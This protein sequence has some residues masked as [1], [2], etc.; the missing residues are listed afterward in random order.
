M[1]PKK[2]IIYQY[3]SD[4]S[5]MNLA[6]EFEGDLPKA[7]YEDMIK[8]D[9]MRKRRAA[10]AKYTGKNQDRDMFDDGMEI[11]VGTH[12]EDNI[13]QHK[14]LKR[15]G[16]ATRGTAKVVR[17]RGVVFDY[18]NDIIDLRVRPTHKTIGGKPIM[19]TPKTMKLSVDFGDQFNHVNK[20]GSYKMNINVHPEK[21]RLDDSK[22]KKIGVMGI[23][24]QV[25]GEKNGL[26]VL[27][28]GITNMGKMKRKMPSV[29]MFKGT[30]L[31][32]SSVGIST[33][34]IGKKGRRFTV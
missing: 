22:I 30:Q 27:E 15:F 34:L 5:Y 2:R 25:E 31:D 21:H 16:P 9:L 28:G 14:I 32:F 12:N 3:T 19:K 4:N 23:R 11:Q 10:I 13:P 17:G 24:K 20:A 7:E 26:K 8:E 6:D 1:P 33:G 29:D 18:D